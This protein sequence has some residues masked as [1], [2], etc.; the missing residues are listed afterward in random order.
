MPPG[1]L[2]GVLVLGAVLAVVRPI[3]AAAQAELQVWLNPELGKQIPRADYRYTLYPDRNVVAQEGF[4]GLQEHRATLFTP[5][6]QDS[7]DEFGLSIKALYQNI[8]TEARFP[9]KGGLF[10]DELWDLSAGLSYRHKF[11]NG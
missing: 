7:T 6:Y 9:D 8:D 1:R 5:F 10:P 3:P 4:F 2:V 11:D